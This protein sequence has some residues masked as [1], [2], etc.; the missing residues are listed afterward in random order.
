MCPGYN[1]VF[2]K[3]YDADWTAFTAE[4]TPLLLAYC[5]V[6][7]P[8][9]FPKRMLDL[10]CG[11]GSVALAFLN[12]GYEVTGVD[13]SPSMLAHAQRKTSSYIKA[14]KAHFIQADV[15]DVHIMDGPFGVV[16]STFGSLN[17]LLTE[18]ALLGAFNTASSVLDE[19]G[20]FVFDLVTELGLREWN[21]VSVEEHEEWLLVDRGFFDQRSRRAVAKLSGFV[22]RK[23]NLFER[24][25]EIIRSQAFSMQSVDDLLHKAGW[26]HVSFRSI[27]DLN[28]SLAEPEEHKRVF[29]VATKHKLPTNLA[30]ESQ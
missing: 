24:F 29:V 30:E 7:M 4:V 8:K 17:H 20:L 13:L 14:G 3:L 9:R 19:G 25:G 18:A 22:K 15:S 21:N 16:V 11:T 12:R 26:R 23:D 28:R 1:E 2:A 6:Q 10:C 5:E 27:N